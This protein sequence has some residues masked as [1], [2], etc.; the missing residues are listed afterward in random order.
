M[1]QELKNPEVNQ[2]N[3]YQ[4][5]YQEQDPNSNSNFSNENQLIQNQN[6]YQQNLGNRNYNS[7]F[8]EPPPMPQKENTNKDNQTKELPKEQLTAILFNDRSQ[9]IWTATSKFIAG[10]PL[11]NDPELADLVVKDIENRQTILEKQGYIQEAYQLKELLQ[12][13][14]I[15][16]I[17]VHK[18]AKT[19]QLDQEISQQ[20]QKV[21]E[22]MQNKQKQLEK[23][24]DELNQKFNHQYEAMLQRHQ[25][26][27]EQLDNDWRSDS[28]RRKYSHISQTLRE[29][30]RQE[31]IQKEMNHFEEYKK[32]KTEADNL[33][34][35]ETQE[36]AKKWEG[37][38]INAVN[39]PNK[40][41]AEEI[42]S[43]EQNATAKKMQITRQLVIQNEL[44]ERKRKALQVKQESAQNQMN[45]WEND[46]KREVASNQATPASHSSKNPRLLKLP[47]LKNT[48]Q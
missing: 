37:D 34:Q 30:R 23:Q 41:Q 28:K 47:P 32:L 44:T 45:K 42:K 39:A 8:V 18:T 36:A 4:D 17:E 24:E 15:Q 5:H 2:Q 29:L 14:R 10:A 19:Q 1:D 11:P 27:R 25:Q 22:Q 38:Y 6:E 43:F 7:N 21:E 12:Q 26:E 48:P 16:T 35:L 20:H 33:E 13:A 9:E 40:R 3:E 46:K 31:S